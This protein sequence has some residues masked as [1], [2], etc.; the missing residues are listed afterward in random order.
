VSWELTYVERRKNLEEA[1]K[2]SYVYPDQILIHTENHAYPEEEESK[3]TLS[4][5]SLITIR[6]IKP[7]DE[8]LLQD[9]FYS[10][11]DETVYLRYFRQV[12]T[13]PH[14]TAQTMVNLDYQERMAFV[15][16]LGEI[17]L[18][19]IMAWADMR[20]RKSTKDSWRSPTR[21]MKS[22][23]AGVS[24]PCFSCTLKTTPN[25]RVL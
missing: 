13:M 23:R 15:A 17:G 1:K 25:A 24:A 7:T 3:E 18:E 11:S 5:G 8:P 9:F 12:R 6:P 20:R 19:K 4:D 22:I 21:C 14:I 16:T 2:R 10:H